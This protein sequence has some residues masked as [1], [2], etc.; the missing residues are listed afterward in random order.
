[1]R[2]LLGFTGCKVLKSPFKGLGFTADIFVS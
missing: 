1:M 2:V